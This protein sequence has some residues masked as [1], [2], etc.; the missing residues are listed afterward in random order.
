MDLAGGKASIVSLLR[1]VLRFCSAPPAYRPEDKLPVSNARHTGAAFPGLNVATSP[2][3]MCSR[4]EG[5][6][7]AACASVSG[8]PARTKASLTNS[9]QNHAFLSPLAASPSCALARPLTHCWR[10]SREGV[11]RAERFGDHIRDKLNN[12]AIVIPAVFDLPGKTFHRRCLVRRQ[13]RHPESK[14]F[15]AVRQ[16]LL[17]GNHCTPA[18]VASAT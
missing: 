5:L 1:T 8:C 6:I 2:S 14:E 17:K 13:V 4:S 16:R 12:A 11:E 15:I 7:H 9:E 18:P 10:K 3:R